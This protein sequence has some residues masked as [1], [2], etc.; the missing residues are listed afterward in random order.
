M[1]LWTHCELTCNTSLCLCC[2]WVLG[3]RTGVCFSDTL[4]YISSHDT[5]IKGSVF[6]WVHAWWSRVWCPGAIGHNPSKCA[7]THT[8]PPWNGHV[9]VSHMADIFEEVLSSSGFFVLIISGHHLFR[10]QLWQSMRPFYSVFL[11][12]SLQ[13]SKDNMQ[14][15]KCCQGQANWQCFLTWCCNFDSLHFILRKTHSCTAV[16]K[17]VVRPRS[18]IIFC[19]RRQC[20]LSV[21][22]KIMVISVQKWQDKSTSTNCGGLYF[23]T[24]LY[25]ALS[26]FTMWITWPPTSLIVPGIWCFASRTS[27]WKFF[28]TSK[29]HVEL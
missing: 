23:Y 3:H 9:R 6:V 22:V 4:I 1:L 8:H 26:G 7:R 10:V 21:G 28:R 24:I 2:V 12:Y 14:H 19:F 13:I 11:P 16:L 25:S 17:S 5:D 18:G 27:S 29:L 20:L 15:M